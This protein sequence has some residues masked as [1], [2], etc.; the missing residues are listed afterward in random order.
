MWRRARL[1]LAAFALLVAPAASVAA[2]STVDIP[3]SPWAGPVFTA[4]GGVVVGVQQS[5][6][7]V[8]ILRVAPGTTQLQK[9]T[10]IAVPTVVTHG[11][12]WTGVDM[13]LMPAGQG[14]FLYQEKQGGEIHCCDWH[15]FDPKLTWFAT[16]GATGTDE[17]I[18]DAGT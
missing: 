6:G 1:A 9:V 10:S 5:A 12:A 16:P 7:K 4:D 11:G 15:A 18:C 8:D 14:F 3:G 17:P 2:T 13:T